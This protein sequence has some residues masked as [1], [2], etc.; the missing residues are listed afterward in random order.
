MNNDLQTVGGNV[1]P[2]R[3]NT[4]FFLGSQQCALAGGA[5]NKRAANSVLGKKVS[6]S[7]D[8]FKIDTAI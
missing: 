3:G 2:A 1:G 8:D 6:L 5:A 7:F 4:L